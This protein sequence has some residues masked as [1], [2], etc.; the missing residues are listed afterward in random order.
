MMKKVGQVTPKPRRVLGKGKADAEAIANKR[1]YVAQ[2]AKHV[3]AI[4]D[5]FG[6]AE[7]L[8]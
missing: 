6:T 8:D 4:I 7:V 2:R 3:V 5:D 1:Y